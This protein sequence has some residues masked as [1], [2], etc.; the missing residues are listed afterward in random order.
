M[1]AKTK[2][3]SGGITKTVVVS[4]AGAA[5]SGA[6]A[7]RASAERARR[8]V[9]ARMEAKGLLL[10]DL[11]P[12]TRTLYQNAGKALEE[13]DYAS[14]TE[15]YNEIEQVIDNTT[16]NGDFVKAKMV[17]INRDIAQKAANEATQKQIN[18]LLAEVS[19]AMTEGRYDRANRKIN[20]LVSL[21]A[22]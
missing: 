1:P 13:K 9:R 8:Q 16:V 14:A 21:L 20:Q 11:P 7:T 17:R 18:L 22:K 4:N 10:D 5:S 3:P 6:P 12:A 2:T 15:S 19:D